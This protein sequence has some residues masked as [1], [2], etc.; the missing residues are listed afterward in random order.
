[1]GKFSLNFKNSSVRYVYLY[2]LRILKFFVIIRDVF[3]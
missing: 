3:K 2:C 1:M